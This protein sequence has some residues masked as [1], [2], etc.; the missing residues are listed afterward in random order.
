MDA[1]KLLDNFDLV[2]AAPG[3]VA[4]VREMILQLAV[5]GQLVPPEKA[6]VDGVA[7]LGEM[8]NERAR[9]AKSGATMTRKA[10]SDSMVEGLFPIP[11]HWAWGCLAEVSRNFGQK[12]PS[13]PFTYIDVGSI[14]GKRGSVKNRLAILRPN[15]APSRARKIVRVGSVIYSTV[16]PYLMNIAIIEEIYEPEPIASTAFGILHPL[17]GMS[18]GF[19]KHYLRSVEFSRFIESQ[20]VGIAYPAVNDSKLFSAPVPVPPLAEQKRIVA[21]VDELMSLCDKLE[22]GLAEEAK[23]RQRYAVAVTRTLIEGGIE[24]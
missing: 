6:S 16:R 22:R 1:G 9:L 20:M 4:R 11:R 24:K 17:S 3:G 7:L 21:K 18:A 5:R 23:L 13:E 19:L 14:D 15:E 12:I 8:R 10:N 2:I